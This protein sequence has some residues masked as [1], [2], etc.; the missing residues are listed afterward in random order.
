M[1]KLRAKAPSGEDRPLFQGHVDTVQP[2]RV[3]GWAWN[4]NHP[5]ERISVDLLIDGT[6]QATV[7]AEV[8]RKDLLDA[9]IGDGRYGFSLLVPDEAVSTGRSE[10]R[11]RFSGTDVDVDGTPVEI[12]M[13]Q[14]IEYFAGD[15]VDN[16]NLRCPFCL[17]D[18]TNIRTTHKMTKETFQKWI[19]I[20]PLVRDGRF[21]ISCLHE[22]TLHPE[23]FDFI[24]MIPRDLRK[25]VFFTTNICKPL[26]DEQIERL[27][28][29]GLSH[30]NI[31]M[32]TLDE[33]LFAVLRKG[34]RQRIFLD[35]LNRMI[36]A[37]QASSSAPE[38]R[39]ITMAYS[40]NLD[41]IPGMVSRAFEEFHAARHE[42]RY[43][44]NVRHITE[45]FRKE[46]FLSREDWTRLDAEL[47]KLPHAIDVILPPDDYETTQVRSTNYWVMPDEEGFPATVPEH[48][49]ALRGAWDGEVRIR[50]REEHFS[51][52]VNILENPAAFFRAI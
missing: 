35:N 45:E 12:E 28:T 51:V 9:G 25:K 48:P 5:D 38:L 10:F 23:L 11:V 4:K 32:D 46:H 14:P 33:N 30:I 18:Y 44:Y 41:E 19:E 29:S 36:P 31:S 13:D 50:R 43:T 6:V 2:D 42:V 52:N 8:F 49:I 40:T 17:V 21:F 24:D 39:Y 16:C 47:A 15:I 34:G 26:K 3:V 20:M 1:F 22:P 7:R 37:F 27:A